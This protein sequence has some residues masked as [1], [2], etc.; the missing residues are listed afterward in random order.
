MH[1][2]CRHGLAICMELARSD[3]ETISNWLRFNSYSCLISYLTIN[4]TST[5]WRIPEAKINEDHPWDKIAEEHRI[6]ADRTVSSSVNLPAARYD[7]YQKPAKTMQENR[8]C[9]Y[10]NLK[11]YFSEI[12]EVAAYSSNALLLNGIL[13]KFIDSLNG[14]FRP[15]ILGRKV[16]E[17]QS[18]LLLEKLLKFVSEVSTYGIDKQHKNQIEY[19][20]SE[21]LPKSNLTGTCVED[22]KL[23]KNP[24]KRKMLK[25]LPKSLNYVKSRPSRRTR[26]RNS[27]RASLMFRPSA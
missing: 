5:R 3:I 22:R 9:T 20:E 18:E 21:I 8:F 23:I 2:P 14:A 12:A 24:Q 25:G 26:A 11:S 10:S 17:G 4:A 16:G 13:E 15:E 19:V 6:N 1:L 27:L 7:D